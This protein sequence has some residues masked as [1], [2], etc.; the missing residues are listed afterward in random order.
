MVSTL[1][2]IDLDGPRLG[3]TIKTTFIAFLTVVVCSISISYRRVWV[4][5]L[6]HILCMIFQ[7]KYFS[8]YT[9]FINWPNLIVWLSVLLEILGNYVLST[10]CWPVRDVINFEIYLSCLIKPFFYKTEKSGQKCK[11]LKNKKR[12]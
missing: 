10:I 8:C 1:V 7:E 2:L 5:L 3:H 12:F 4:K 9:L 6:H 11:Y